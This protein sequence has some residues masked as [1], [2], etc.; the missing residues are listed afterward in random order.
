MSPLLSIHK[1]LIY[2]NPL[3][4]E[5]DLRNFRLEGEA[6]ITFPNGRMRMEN[7]LD[8]AEGQASNFVYWCP[9][10]FPS[11]I[12][13]EWDFWPVREPGLCMLFFA[14]SGRHGEDLFD[15]RLPKRTGE[16]Q[17][18]HSGAIHALHVSYFR[19]R[20]PE[21]RA[22][23]T[24]NLRKSFGAH[25]VCRGADPIPGVEDAQSPYRLELTKLGR[26]VV[27]VINGLT[28]FQWRDDG[29]SYGP[30]LG[31]G[32]IGFRQ[33]APLIGEYGNFRVYAS[34]KA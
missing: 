34:N 17:Q 8:P 20:Y 31:E 22:F 18:Y 29:Q 28:V 5:K 10:D 9:E 24:C 25:L 11:D 14:A 19:R 21:E 1:R 26:D 33:M 15:P 23:H 4:S 27:F 7:M 30:L 3:S 6:S 13:V 16:Y 2:E 32:K 12:T